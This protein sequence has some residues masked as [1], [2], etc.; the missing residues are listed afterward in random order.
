[1]QTQL[2]SSHDG[3]QGD[4]AM[5]GSGSGEGPVWRHP[6]GEIDDDED[7][8]DDDRDDDEASGSGV[9]PI[10]TGTVSYIL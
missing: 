1:M 2:A 7:G 10:T 5:D 6:N 8:H 9:G 4:E 3:Y